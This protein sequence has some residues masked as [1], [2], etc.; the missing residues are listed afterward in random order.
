MAVPLPAT[1]ALTTTTIYSLYPSAAA[2]C[3]CYQPAPGP[4]PLS[5]DVRF[6]LS[7][8]AY[9]HPVVL[10][11]QLRPSG[12]ISSLH[13]YGQASVAR[14]VLG[15]LPQQILVGS[16]TILA[17][18]GRPSHDGSFFIGCTVRMSYKQ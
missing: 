15:P 13:V 5:L 4:R 17:R 8:G 11:Q 12:C 9:T 3:L 14:S 6:S 18:L 7:P 10:L 2:H 1:S 16:R